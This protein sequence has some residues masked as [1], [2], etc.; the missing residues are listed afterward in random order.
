MAAVL[1]GLSVVVWHWLM[2]A[3]RPVMGWVLLGI[4]TN[5]LAFVIILD[6]FPQMRVFVLQDLLKTNDPYR[7]LGTG[8]VGRTAA[9]AEVL[10]IWMEAPLFGVGFRQH[11]ASLT[12]ASS[13]HN[14]YLT[15]LIDTGIFGFVVY[16]AFIGFSFHAALRAIDEPRT[17]RVI[18]AIIVSYLV[19]GLF[20]RRALNSGNPMSIWFIIACFYA[21]RVR[22]SR[23]S[24]GRIFGLAKDLHG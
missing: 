18:L 7:G 16:V 21:L 12:I 15:M 6:L 11:E 19:V 20:E 4:A 1:A 10:E 24:R 3:R 8:F 13:A 2:S 9:W 17:K 22:A 14:A 5:L 23:I